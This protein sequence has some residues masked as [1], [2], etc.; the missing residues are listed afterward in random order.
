[1]KQKTNGVADSTATSREGVQGLF[2]DLDVGNK[3]IEHYG[4][5]VSK[6]YGQFAVTENEQQILVGDAK[7]A[8]ALRSSKV[9][10]AGKVLTQK[11]FNKENFKLQMWSLWKPK[12]NVFIMDLEN[13]RFA[14]GFNTKQEMTVIQ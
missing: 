7:E 13:D 12:A 4:R 14:F 8:S 2:V 10:L 11:P 5:Q 9:F 3:G 1:M 6:F